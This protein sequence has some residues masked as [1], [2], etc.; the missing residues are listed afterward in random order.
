MVTRVIIGSDR[1]MCRL[2]QLLSPELCLVLLGGSPEWTVSDNVG[3]HAI[4]LVCTRG[5][6]S[7]SLLRGELTLLKRAG[8][9]LHDFSDEVMDCIGIKLPSLRL[10]ILILFCERLNL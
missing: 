8:S 5:A 1:E 3:V 4:S 10:G 6:P 7:S 9:L 2:F